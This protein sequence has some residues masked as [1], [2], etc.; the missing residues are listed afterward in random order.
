MKQVIGY[1]RVSSREQAEN[2]HALEQQI[3][4]LRQAGAQEVFYDV[5]SGASHD[6]QQFK[7]VI[8]LVNTNQVEILIATRWDRL[9]RDSALYLYLKEIFLSSD[10]KL[11]LLDQGEVDLTTASGELH[12]D[13]QALFAGHERRQLRERI[14]RGNEYRRSKKVAWTRAPWGYTIQND[15]YVLNTT[16]IVCVLAERPA[17]YQELSNEPD[18]SPKLIGIS[19]SQIARETIDVFL[20]VKKTRQTLQYLYQ[21][22]GVE[23]KNSTRQKL[24]AQKGLA[25][26]SRKRESCNP[27]LTQELLF[28]N[29]PS[30]LKEWLENPVLQG[31]TAYCKTDSLK[32]K[33]PIEQWQIHYDTHPDQRLV[34]E[35]EFT[36]IQSLLQINAKKVSIPGRTFYLTG[37]IY[38]QI[39]GRRAVLKNSQE[40]KYYGCRHSKVGCSNTG[41]VRLAKIDEAIIHELFH[42][43]LSLSP[44]H[45]S[46]ESEPPEITRL[47]KDLLLLEQ[48]P[49]LADNPRL[50][51]AKYDLIQEIEKLTHQ[52]KVLDFE[53]AT[54]QEIIQH[55]QARKVTF[56]YS[57]T[58]EE[59]EVVYQKL[60]SQVLIHEQQVVSVQLRV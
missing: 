54:A 21:K 19:R 22:Y 59:R 56:W 47:R 13:L 53:V 2:Q 31:H 16:P 8:A 39:C 3:H 49:G 28:W 52:K 43:A 12:A 7:K 9:T 60:V 38:C 44:T 23:I 30:H 4:R 24:N 5:E 36:E 11:K 33:K 1:A 46:V 29:A 6:R 40:H 20:E 37:L 48:H 45:E 10:V 27:V 58:Q 17:N 14:Q 26:P 32:R 57:L 41:C 25:N 51:Q 42:R 35:S 34:S 50:Q 15:K 55:P 18:H